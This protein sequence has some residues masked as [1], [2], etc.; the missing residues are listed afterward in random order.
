MALRQSDDGCNGI[1][2]CSS[3]RLGLAGFAPRGGQDAARPRYALS[4]RSRAVSSETYQKGYIVPEG[5]LEQIPI[6]ASQEQVLILLGTPS[7]V[8]TVSARLSTTSPSAPS[9]RSPSCSS[10]LWIS[11]SSRSIS[12]RIAG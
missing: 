1:W 8:A 2:E 5:A 7:T 3:K 11:A 10:R 9:A 12:T 6:G 4:F